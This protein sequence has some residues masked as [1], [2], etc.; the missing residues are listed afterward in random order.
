[1]HGELWAFG[2]RLVITPLEGEYGLVIGSDPSIEV[3][4]DVKRGD[5]KPVVNLSFQAVNH[6]RPGF[7]WEHYGWDKL[8]FEI[9]T[10]FAPIILQFLFDY[11]EL[12][13]KV[14]K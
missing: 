10:K 4:P 12:V 11:D 1:M 13:K 8:P 9:P 14:N 6:N 2:S 7:G 5:A 3:F